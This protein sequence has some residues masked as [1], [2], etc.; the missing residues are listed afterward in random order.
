MAA[1]AIQPLGVAAGHVG[2][3]PSHSVEMGMD[4]DGSMAPVA[5]PGRDDADHNTPAM[6][7]A[8][9]SDHCESGSDCHAGSCCYLALDQYPLN[10]PAG[11]NL[12]VVTVPG[13]YESHIPPLLTHPPTDFI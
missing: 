3:L 5:I 10:L 13:R 8:S 4:H 9:T 2:D 7:G 6:Q 11:T 12:L 1:I